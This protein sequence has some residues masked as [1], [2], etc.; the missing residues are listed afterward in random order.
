MFSVLFETVLA[1]SWALVISV[2][3]VVFLAFP[4][5][6]WVEVSRAVL[7]PIFQRMGPA[8]ARAQ[9]GTT[10]VACLLA[11]LSAIGV[12]VAKL[13]EV[14]SARPLAVMLLLLAVLLAV[15]TWRT[16]MIWLGRTQVH[17]LARRAIFQLFVVPAALYFP[18]IFAVLSFVAARVLSSGGAHDSL[19]ILGALLGSG[20]ATGMLMSAS[21][22]LA[23]W[24]AR[25]AQ[26]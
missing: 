2:L 24:V 4:F 12:L 5:V 7:R 1:F 10:D 21:Q 19:A 14:R 16:A 15:T 26:A 13:A 6:V 22:Q 23:A 17:G 3:A 20:L 8:Q 25:D 18:L 9:F 11:E